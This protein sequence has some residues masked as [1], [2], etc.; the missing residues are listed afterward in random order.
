MKKVDVKELVQAFYCLSISAHVAHVN[1]RSFSEHEALGEFYGK[2]NDFKDR[3]VEYMTGM[4][5][6]KAVELEEIE[7]EDVM[8]EAEEA[9]YM[10]ESFASS[11]ADEALI[12]MAGEFKEVK[13]KL[14]YMLMLK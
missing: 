14:K 12:N 3:L 2:V 7:M 6:I 13:G 4:G 5:Y 9:C 8:S 10:L 11:M 1:T